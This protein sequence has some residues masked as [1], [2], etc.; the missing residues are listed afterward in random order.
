DGFGEE[1]SAIKSGADQ[2]MAL[3]QRIS[4]DA[5]AGTSDL[6]GGGET[7]QRLDLRKVN[8]WTPLETLEE[9]FS[10][11]GFYL[12]GHPLDQYASVL[13]K[14][15]VMSFRE[16]EAATERGVLAGRLAGIVIQARERKSQRGNP[17]AFAMFSDATGQFEAVMFSE[18]LNAA[19]D[20]LNPG[21]PL[22]LSVE[23]ERE[24]DT[25]KLRV[26]SVEALDAAAARVERSLKLILAPTLSRRAQAEAFRDMAKA[27][28]PF[29]ASGVGAAR[30]GSIKV[31]L[32]VFEGRQIA[33]VELAG[34][35]DVSPMAAGRL[36]AIDGVER[37]DEI[38]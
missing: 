8:K 9:E 18:T 13:E 16:F 32:P 1:R 20:H 36:Q 15:G 33:E 29:N 21:T 31:E 28:A 4:A 26:Q 17:F 27:L 30:G 11:I 24:D 5:A 25:L 3:A 14:L 23:A 22:V 7:T 12:S 37:V 6:F 35:F 19:R 10:A 2:V 34:R 38:K